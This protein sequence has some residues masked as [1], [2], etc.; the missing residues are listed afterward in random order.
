MR[1]NFI[2]ATVLAFVGLYLAVL[3][4]GAELFGLEIELSGGLQALALLVGLVLFI[5]CFVMLF[6]GYDPATDD[7]QVRNPTLTRFLFE[8]P[9]SAPLWLGVRLYLGVEWLLAGWHKL[10]DP[11]WMQG[12]S[13]LR[14]YW[15][16]AIAIPEEGRPPISYPAYREFIE[17]LMGQ[18]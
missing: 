15:E 5:A 6:R 17:S 2:V 10:T 18:E 12:G 7:M 14:S 16:R 11:E 8:S 9:R 4:T 3:G 1:R 13:A